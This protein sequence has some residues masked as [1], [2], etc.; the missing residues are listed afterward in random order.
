M[1]EFP[2]IPE[3]LFLNKFQQCGIGEVFGAVGRVESCRLWG[4]R[5]LFLRLAIYLRTRKQCKA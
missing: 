4:C 3:S 5:F 1:A 2:E